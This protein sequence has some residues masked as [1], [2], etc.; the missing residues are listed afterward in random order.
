MKPSIKH[1]TADCYSIVLYL[2]F[3]DKDMS[4]FPNVNGSTTPGQRAQ[5]KGFTA[6]G[7]AT[8]TAE[9]KQCG[10]AVPLIFCCTISF[11]WT[12]FLIIGENWLLNIMNHYFYL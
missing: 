6:I 1:F 9:L 12:I 7:K 10:S 11:K 4:C 8:P 5:N 2:I 3:H